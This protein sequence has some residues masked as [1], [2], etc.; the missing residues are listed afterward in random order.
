M[1]VLAGMLAA[2]A[3]G[4][5][6]PSGAGAERPR[7][8][9][10][11]ALLGDVVQQAVGSAAEVTV[12]M[13]ATASP[14][15]F[16]PSARQVALLREAD[17]V[18]ANGGGL[19]VGLEDALG[20]AEADGVAVFR[21]AEA[22]HTGSDPEVG[23]ETEPPADD[24]GHDG[25]SDDGGEH[26]PSEGADEHAHGADA[27]FFTSPERMADA[28]VALV[29]FLEGVEGIDMPVVRSRSAGYL[30]ELRALDQEVADLLDAVPAERRLLVTNH[31]VMSS[32]AERYG[33]E[34]VGT[35][36]P[37]A[38]TTAGASA[39]SL[40]GLVQLVRTRAIPAV[41]VDASAS[42]RLARTLA[43]EVPGVKVV[44]LHTEA[45]GATSDADTY[46]EVVRFNAERIAEALR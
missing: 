3:C 21:A 2:G 12:L 18:V 14:H 1:A 39:S 25:A 34:V 17:A 7:L 11:T 6:D 15:D 4:G 19:E 26:R 8:V 29:A 38:T 22:P 28:V 32:F 9:V 5:P 43:E 16:Q 40:T 42:D 27:H 44:A 45:L 37:S 24:H 33:F 36:L 13:P 31:D 30:D 23:S 41:F 10:T 20:A 46:L 35:V